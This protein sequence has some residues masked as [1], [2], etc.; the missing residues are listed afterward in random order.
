M[1]KENNV[2]K[3]GAERDNPDVPVAVMIVI[4]FGVLTVVSVLA[5][6]G[7]FE[8]VQGEEFRRKVVDVQ[9][10]ELQKNREEGQA[11]ITGYRWIDRDQGVVS[12]PIEKAM[13]LTVQRMEH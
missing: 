5:L 8:Y 2:L 7:Y 9:P 4:L 3:A 1:R 11:R 6:Q 13:E 12:I 10:A